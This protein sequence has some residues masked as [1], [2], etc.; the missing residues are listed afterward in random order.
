[1]IR[2]WKVA[3]HEAC[4]SPSAHSGPCPEVQDFFVYD[5]CEAVV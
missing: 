5:L 2:Q 1:L 3:V 4:S